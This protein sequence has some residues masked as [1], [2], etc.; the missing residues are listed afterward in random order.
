MD[1]DELFPTE[2][3]IFSNGLPASVY[4]AS[5]TKTVERN[6]HWMQ[7]FNINGLF[8]QRF[9]GTAVK[10]P[11]ILDK[12]L[13]NVRSGSEK[14]GRIFSVMYD[15]RNGNNETQVEDLIKSRI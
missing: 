9:I 15:I 7:D 11:N 3:S 2:L 10:Y 6:C 13:S 8:L 1:D 12:V 5:K 4:S 14:Y